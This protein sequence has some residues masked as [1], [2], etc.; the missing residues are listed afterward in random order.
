MKKEL[1]VKYRAI[2]QGKADLDPFVNTNLFRLVEKFS[3]IALYMSMKNEVNLEGLINKL[4]LSKK[5]L[6]HE[7]Y[8]P[9]VDNGLK[10]H[11][12]YKWSDLTFDKAQI[13]APIHNEEIDLNFLDAVVMPC[14]AASR[15]GYRL[16]YGAGYYDRAL[17]NYQGIKIG[18]VIEDCLIDDHFEEGFDIQLDYI[19]TEKAIYPITKRS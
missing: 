3:K 14:I 1:R 11:R 15:A 10:F 5:P 12:F 8:F 7:I 16:G 2:R 17:A 13:L 9:A 6:T 19:V 18:V 4:L